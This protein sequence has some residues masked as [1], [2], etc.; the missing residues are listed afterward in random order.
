MLTALCIDTRMLGALRIDTRM[1]T[2]L[3]IDTCLLSAL[4]IDTRMLAAMRI[5]GLDASI[6]LK[7]RSLARSIAGAAGRAIWTGLGLYWQCGCAWAR[8]PQPDVEVEF[9]GGCTRILRVRRGLGCRHFGVLLD[10]YPRATQAAKW[11]LVW[12]KLLSLNDVGFVD[13]D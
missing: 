13:L 11:R 6:L 8:R 9:I 4:R 1:L 12:R 10:E 2:A 3:R 5:T 7:T